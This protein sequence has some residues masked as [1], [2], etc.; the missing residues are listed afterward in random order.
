MF[1]SQEVWQL[2]TI[3]YRLI[4]S[5]VSDNLHPKDFNVKG[6]VITNFNSLTL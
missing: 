1:S 3:D 5:L 6:F 2:T 4:S